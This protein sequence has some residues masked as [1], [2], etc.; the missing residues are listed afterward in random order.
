MAVTCEDNLLTQQRDQQ[1]VV[2]LPEE[3]DVTNSPGVRQVLLAAISRRPASVV[4]DM[5]ATTFCD[6]SGT[7]A[8]AAAYR[9]AVAVGADMRLVIGHPAVRRVFELNG[10]DTIIRVYPD[11]PAALSG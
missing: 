2:T 6:S 7:S 4:A 10:V 5:T 9:Q 11:L 1:V 8:I 3:I